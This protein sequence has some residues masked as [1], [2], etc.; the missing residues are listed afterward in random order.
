M[1]RELSRKNQ[2]IS[3][4]QCLEI[5]ENEVRGI[6][7]VIGDNGYPYGMPMNYY[8]DKNDGK[9]YFHCGK[10]GHR[11]DALKKCNKVSFCVTDKGTRKTGEWAINFRSVI[12][13]GRVDFIED[14]DEI[15][16]ISRALSYKFTSDTQYIDKEIELYAHKTLCF[17][18]TPENIC[19]K[20]VNEA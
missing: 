15:I 5:L 2:Q 18:L 9:L 6:L 1:F 16:R 12:I 7:S 11:T 14:I 10:N 19:G 4:E 20:R 13:F 17:S 8:Y 3:C